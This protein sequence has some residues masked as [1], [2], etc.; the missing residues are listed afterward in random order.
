[1]RNLTRARRT[2]LATLASTALLALPSYA[3]TTADENWGSTI[4]IG[5]PRGA[6]LRLIYAGL[7]CSQA[8]TANC[9]VFDFNSPKSRGQGHLVVL[10]APNDNQGFNCVVDASGQNVCVFQTP[11]AN[12]GAATTF[13][14]STGPVRTVGSD[15]PPVGATRNLATTTAVVT[16]SSITNFLVLNTRYTPFDRYLFTA[17]A[18]GGACSNTDLVIEIYEDT[19]P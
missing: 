17:R 5:S 16:D 8:T 10:F 18:N 6:G 15:V 3:N 9:A 2:L 14:F 13:T 12:C 7:V 4:N 1:M 19:A 11:G